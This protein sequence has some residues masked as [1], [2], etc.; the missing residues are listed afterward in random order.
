MVRVQSTKIENLSSTKKKLPL[1]GVSTTQSSALY[2]V[3]LDEV[4]D[5]DEVL[6]KVL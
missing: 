6:A 5:G 1:Y 3:F 4:S 2:L